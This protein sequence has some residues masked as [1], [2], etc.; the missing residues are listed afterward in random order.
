MW[1][2]IT[3]IHSH[4]HT[5]THLKMH[6]LKLRASDIRGSCQVW[7]HDNQIHQI[8]SFLMT[9]ITCNTPNETNVQLQFLFCCPVRSQILKRMS[10][11]RCPIGCWWRVSLQISGYGLP[12]RLQTRLQAKVPNHTGSADRW[13]RVP[14]RKKSTKGLWAKLMETNVGYC[15]F[16]ETSWICMGAPDITV[17]PITLL[18][19]L[20]DSEVLLEAYGWHR[21]G[22]CWISEHK[23]ER[24]K[25]CKELHAKSLHLDCARGF[26][27]LF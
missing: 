8:P 2:L 13:R 25:K 11:C 9:S 14:A 20:T 5:H 15:Y 10:Q 27:V 22:R 26:H 21:L 18:G 6:K 3:I 4:S 12:P 24:R 16:S 1:Y 7:T 23:Q 19:I 17:A